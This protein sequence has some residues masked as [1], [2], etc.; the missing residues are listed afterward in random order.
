MDENSF[1]AMGTTKEVM[2]LGDIRLK[3]EAFGFNA[4]NANGHDEND[5]LDKI[6]T[7]LAMKDEKPKAIVAKTVKGYGVSFMA[8][9][10]IWHYTRLTADTYHKALEELKGRSS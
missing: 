8:G 5:L 3:L 9:N 4:L 6:N 10:N 2:D 1:Q 7:L